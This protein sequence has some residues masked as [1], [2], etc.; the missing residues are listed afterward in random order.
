M[1]DQNYKNKTKEDRIAEKIKLKRK[2]AQVIDSR[3]EKDNITNVLTETSE[4][5]NWSG[6]DIYWIV[7]GIVIIWKLIR[8]LFN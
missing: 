2:K 3:K 1:R 4:K 6:K 8:G 5:R 7:I